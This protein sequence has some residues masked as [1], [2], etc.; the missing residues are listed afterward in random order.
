MWLAAV[1]GWRASMR[2]QIVNIDAM[3]PMRISSDSEVAA[4]TQEFLT[5]RAG[6]VNSWRRSGIRSLV[7]KQL[8]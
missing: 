7:R 3:A 6:P 5:R 8:A 2:S 1:L 4:P